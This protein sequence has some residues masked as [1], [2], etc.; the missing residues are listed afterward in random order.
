MKSLVYSRWDGSQ[1][2]FSLDAERALDALSDLMME[3]MTAAEALEWMRQYGFQMAGMDFRVM[4]IDEMISELRDQVR[5]LEQQY[6]LDLTQDDLSRRFADIL[7]R[8]HDALRVQQ[9][10]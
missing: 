5:S 9:V 1:G 2:E 7:R 3:G 6:R 4:G 8:E 10:Y